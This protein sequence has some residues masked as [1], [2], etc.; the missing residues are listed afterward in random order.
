MGA[1]YRAVV[2]RGKGGLDQ[3]EIEELPTPEPGPGEVRIRVRATGAGATDL[4][5]RSGSYPY[6]PP[7]PFTPGYEVVGE[8]EALGEG[9]KGLARGQRVCALTVHGGQAEVLV[10]EADHFVPVPDVLDDAEVVALILNYVTAYQMIHRVAA[11]SAGQTA[12]VTGANGGVGSAALELLRV[13]GVRA[14]G[15]SSKR[16]FD[17]V[18]A[19]GAIP[20]EARTRRLDEQVHSVHA[21]G[22]DASFDGLGGAGTRECIRATRIGGIVVGYGFVAAQKNGRTS[23]PTALRG[24]A[25]LYLGAR[26][27]RRRSTFFGI[28]RVYRK[29]RRP[30]KEDL[31]V[32]FALLRDRKIHPQIAARLPL[33]DGVKAQE[34]LEAGGLTGKIVLLR[35][36]RG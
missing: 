27:A 10:R 34:M 18:R 11:M 5:M 26:L 25:S 24:V 22:V 19:L 4:I 20:I 1:T 17:L 16:H 21:A 12:L 15:S 33:L 30:F 32:L 3:L 28:T 9:V 13:H 14:V 29:D 36:H 2:L 23:V 31:P 7:F 35:D 6:A 8:V